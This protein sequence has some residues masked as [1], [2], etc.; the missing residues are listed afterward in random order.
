MIVISDASPLHYLILIDQIDLLPDLLGSIVIPETVYHELTT[1]KTPLKVIQ[2]FDTNP[3]WLEIKPDTGII[4]EELST[5]DPG[6]REAIL[7]AEALAAD[8]ILIDDLAGRR[9]AIHRGLSV[10]GT[11]GLLEIASEEG[12]VDFL[13]VLSQIK[14]A[15]FFISHALEADLR[16]KHQGR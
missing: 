10:L 3:T 9:V 16:A 5:I 4:D 2:Y 13:D 8:G 11:L 15:G 12:R 14:T 1:E 6:E 7:L